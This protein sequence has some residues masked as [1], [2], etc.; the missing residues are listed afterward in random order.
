MSRKFTAAS[1]EK[2][3]TSIGGCAVLPPATVAAL[4]RIP[5]ANAATQCAW[6]AGTGSPNRVGI[7]IVSSTGQK[8]RMV[9]GGGSSTSITS[10]TLGEWYLIGCSKA[11]GTVAPRHHIYRY[12][13]GTFVHENNAATVADW[14]LPAT[15]TF[16]GALA[17]GTLNFWDGDIET[18]GF[19]N[20]VLTDA[21]FENLPFTLAAWYASAPVGLWALDQSATA[22]KTVDLSGGG[23]NESA[24]TG[25]SVSTLSVPVFNY[26]DG[27]WLPVEVKPATAGTTLACP[28]IASAGAFGTPAVSRAEAAQGVAS[29]QAFGSA[30]VSRG[31]RTQAV[32]SAEAFGVAT[33]R[34]AVGGI[35]LSSAAALGTAAFLRLINAAGITSAG[36]FGADTIRRVIGA[37]GIASVEQPGSPLVIAPQYVRAAGIGSAGA[38]G[39]PSVT[40]GA[41]AAVQTGHGVIP[42]VFPARKQAR[43]TEP[44]RKQPAEKPQRKK[45][46]EPWLDTKPTPPRDTKPRPLTA[47]GGIPS[48]E[49]FGA[50]LVEPP[51]EM[52]EEEL[53]MLLAAVCVLA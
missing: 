37:A 20:R 9:V 12:S 25:T 40:G 35:G 7:Q 18:V 48:L 2:I 14:S 6:C 17:G 23:A 47:V 42:F 30:S 3:T 51:A 38:F 50:L 19:W 27:I 21:E 32:G 49:G 16:L 52:F 4:V 10:L 1:S 41:A 28:G 24:I 44:S 13:D 39:T 26:S 34:R 36:A 45:R 43:K 29:A 22:Q 11:A 8:I 5:D 33:V 31:E 46:T 53:A 15:S